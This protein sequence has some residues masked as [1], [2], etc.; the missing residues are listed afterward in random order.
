[1]KLD[2]RP[3]V[4]GEKDCIEFDFSEQPEEDSLSDIRFIDGIR[5]FG[6]VTD[7]SG[8]MR[9]TLDVSGRYRT[10]CAR[11]LTELER[12]LE[13]HIE[14]DVALKDM[15][16][17]K[18]SDDYVVCEGNELDLDDVISEVMYLELPTRLL[19]SEDCKG[20]CPKCGK[21]LN[22]GDCTCDLHEPDPRWAALKNYFSENK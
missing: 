2:L 5:V 3:L 11:C 9:L 20:L 15:L 17:D 1:M 16:Q 13:A 7:L 14:K 22:E 12:E 10:S 18:E 19:C 6:R 4:N 8:Y 21:N